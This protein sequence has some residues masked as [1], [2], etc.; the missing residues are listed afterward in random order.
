MTWEQTASVAIDA[1]P[2]VVWRVL[3]DGSGWNRWSP[4]VEWMLVEDDIAPG[5]LITLK[6]KGAPQTAFTIEE[7]VPDALLLMRIT[8]GPVAALRLRWA[9]E[10][11]GSGTQVSE[12]VSIDGVVAGL[13]LK[14]GAR[15]IADAMPGNLERFATLCC[16]GARA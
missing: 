11:H 16:E 5:K 12:T 4:G 14:K 3:L 1:P 10:P 15:K 6:P 8:F 9:L 2:D 7:V 13:L